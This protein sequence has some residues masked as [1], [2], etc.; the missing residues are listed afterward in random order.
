MSHLRG[1]TLLC[2]VAVDRYLSSGFP[3]DLYT[4]GGDRLFRVR[5][6]CRK[7]GI[8]RLGQRRVAMHF[9]SEPNHRVPL[10]AGRLF[11]LHAWRAWPSAS[12]RGRYE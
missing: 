1:D 6:D 7:L 12:E 4:R 11:C 8:W 3:R 10:D 9:K 2:L 5:H